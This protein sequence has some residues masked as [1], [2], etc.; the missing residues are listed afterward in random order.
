MKTHHKKPT[1]PKRRAGRTPEPD[2]L[3]DYE[4]EGTLSD[5]ATLTKTIGYS[6]TPDEAAGR[7]KR[8]TVGVVACRVVRI[9]CEHTPNSTSLAELT[10]SWETLEFPFESSGTFFVLTDSKGRVACRELDG[11]HLK[12]AWDFLTQKR[13]TSSW[14]TVRLLTAFRRA[15]RED[16]ANCYTEDLNELLAGDPTRPRVAAYMAGARARDRVHH[17]SHTF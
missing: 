13:V 2:L 17:G 4:V 16:W 7:F 3:F 15:I 8:C 1:R 9:L 6:P 14:K 5:G 12:T 10:V 11:S